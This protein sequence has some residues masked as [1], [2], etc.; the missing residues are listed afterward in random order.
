LLSHDEERE[1]SARAQRGDV[2]ARDELVLCN[3]RLVQG[4]AKRYLRQG[5]PI[6]DLRQEGVLALI[7]AI[8]LYDPDQSRFGTYATCW[9]RAYLY[10]LVAT[11]K[12]IRLPKYQIWLLGRLGDQVATTELADA[13]SLGVTASKLARLKQGYAVRAAQA[14]PTYG[15]LWRIPAPAA[16]DDAQ[17]EAQATQTA[18]GMALASLPERDREV[19]RHRFGLGTPRKTLAVTGQFLGGVTRQR[20]KQIQHRAV[21]TIRATMARWRS[22]EVAGNRDMGTDS[23][24]A[25][26]HH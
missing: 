4:L 3:L 12:L 18:L 25:R 11:Q 1:L 2:A 23:Q 5:V 7:R 19:I 20:V 9:V 16:Q 10:D 8:D 21:K 22:H 24:G 13:A 26:T 14:Q 6:E 17:A 15:L